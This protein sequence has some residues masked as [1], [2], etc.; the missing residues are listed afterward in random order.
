MDVTI[1]GPVQPRSGRPHRWQRRSF[2][3]LGVVGG[4]SLWASPQA[5]ASPGGNAAPGA[6]AKNVLLIYEQ[7]GLSHIDTWDPKPNAPVDHRSPF[8]PIATNVP[9]MQFT[10]LLSHTAKVADK[11]AVVRSMY[12]KGGAINGHPDGTQYALSGEVPDGPLEMPDIGGVVAHKLSTDC[13]Y[14]PPYIMVP[15]NHEQAAMTRQGFLPADTKAFKTG[16]SNL[17]DPA[18][19]VPNLSLLTGIDQGR[20][21]DRRNL[22]SNLNVG[23]AAPPKPLASMQ[24]LRE[25]AVDMLTNPAAISAFNLSEESDA[26]RDQ[27]GR[28]HRG[29]CYLL[30][31]RLI[32]RGVRFVTVDVREPE[33]DATPGGF[34]MNWDHHDLIYTEGSCGTVR[35]K[36]GGEGRYGIGHWVM[37]GSTD[38]AFAALIADLDQRGM[39]DETLVIFATEFGRTPRVNKF[40]GRDHWAHGYSH[41]FAGAGVPGGQ[42]I[43][44]TDEEGGFVVDRPYR[45]ED[46]AA[47]I[48]EKLGIDRSRPIYTPAN[49]PVFLAH[50]GH[51]IEE[52]F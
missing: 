31:R 18:W 27:Y 6:R 45:P 10:S 29:Q 2:I 14:L 32:E 33:T 48:Y 37:M 4:L 39:L 40:Q 42:V 12:H 47:T 38:Q 49:R 28:G 3:G 17:S 50:D 5:T 8:R 44:R 35:N 26:T 22:L 20:F 24:A 30:G 13:P 25:Q 9:G 43:G 46:V 21:R 51:R 19:K 7:G 36:A 41:A 11:L 15:G 52:L 16:G 23:V 34:N 1:A